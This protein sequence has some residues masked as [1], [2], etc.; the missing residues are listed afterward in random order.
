MKLKSK[1]I[2]NFN[3]LAKLTTNGN[4]QEID[5]WFKK[6][7]NILK[8]P[9]QQKKLIIQILNELYFF[10]FQSYSTNINFVNQERINRQIAILKNFNCNI[11]NQLMLFSPTCI[12]DI[13][14]KHV[15][16]F[17]LNK[18][19]KNL[20][21]KNNNFSNAITKLLEKEDFKEI[22]DIN[23]ILGFNT[24]NMKIN[25]VIFHYKE[26]CSHGAFYLDIKEE[27]FSP[28]YNII[29]SF[30]KEKELFFKR[31][32]IEFPSEEEIKNL[33]S[34]LL[35]ELDNNKMWNN[36]KDYKE[37]VRK[38][39]QEYKSFNLHENLD[40]ILN[41]NKKITNKFKI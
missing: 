20:L 4:Y 15:S 25:G 30:T 21:L 28:K 40:S 31:N 9:L 41:I 33:E 29:F 22:E 19:N 13:T 39:F 11:N 38:S 10:S 24:L 34:L 5:N 6:Y 14:S 12:E 26:K 8:K 1:P 35:L 17:N 2:W 36:N 37:K 23:K 18:K 7:E 16:C 3:E 27:I 32:N